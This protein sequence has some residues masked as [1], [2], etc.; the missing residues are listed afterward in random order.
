MSEPQNHNVTQFMSCLDFIISGQIVAPSH[1]LTSKGSRGRGIPL[2]SG[3]PRLLKY[4]NLGR[5]VIDGD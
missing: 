3:K 1:D 5:L 4:Y 2:I